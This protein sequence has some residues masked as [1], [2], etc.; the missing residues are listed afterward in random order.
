MTPAASSGRSHANAGRIL[1]ATRNAGKL[2]ELE[3]MLRAAG[4]DPVDPDAA[5][6]P[7]DAAED[8][9]EAEET[10]AG[11]ARAKARWFHE[12]SGLPTLADDSGL[13]VRAL[14]GAPGV[15]SKRFSGR[16]DLRG[17]ELDA[18][19]NAELLARL[20]RE[21]D[22]SAAFVCAAAFVADGLELVA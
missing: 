5:G 12:R 16:S 1:V 17:R 9:I 3:P 10:F 15:R 21:A 11:N 20:A 22:R 6:I 8:S 14:G 18:A 7:E 19:N 4:F 2:R 13:T